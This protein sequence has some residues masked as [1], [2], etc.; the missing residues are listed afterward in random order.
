[1]LSIKIA[2]VSR[3]QYY[4]PP[5]RGVFA[6]PNQLIGLRTLRFRLHC[7]AQCAMY[8]RKSELIKRCSAAENA[9][10]KAQRTSAAVATP[11]E[12]SAIKH[13]KHGKYPSRRRDAPS[14]IEDIVLS[15][16]AL[17]LRFTITVS[18]NC[19]RCR[20]GLR[21]KYRRKRFRDSC[22]KVVGAKHV[23]DCKQSVGS[24]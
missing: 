2:A 8:H 24:S 18:I 4:Y 7:D 9:V 19:G 22:R 13:H 14:L 23:D 10:P 17:A 6:L 16:T 21:G 20:L 11:I 1:M 5:A 3:L 15:R 12:L